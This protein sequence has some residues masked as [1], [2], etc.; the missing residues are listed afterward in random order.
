M[1]KYLAVLT[2]TAFLGTGC[3]TSYQ[4]GFDAGYTSTYSTGYNQTYDTGV[5]N[6]SADG[7]ID[8]S[9][10][11]YSDGH[12]QGYGQG[13]DDAFDIY[14]ST[15]YQNGYS[16]GSTSGYN[17]GYS[18]GTTLGSNA[19]YSDG[20]AD[21]QDDSYIDNYNM[22]YSD[23]DADGYNDGYAT[24]YGDYFASGYGVGYS[25]GS[26][27]GYNDGYDDG[28][29]DGYYD[30]SMGFSAS[31]NP[32][33]ALAAQVN[34]DLVDYA[35]LP[36][37]DKAQAVSSMALNHADGG[38]VDLEK[39]AAL[40][41][42]HYLGAIKNQLSAKFGLSASSAG[43]IANVVHQFNK[44]AGSRELTVEDASAFSKNLVGFDMASI[45]GAVKKS[46]KG[47]SNDLDLLLD[48]AAGK[49]DMSPENFNNMITTIFF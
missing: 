14:A 43:K 35:A 38:S 5:A 22:G 10:D 25:D 42:Q 40:K 39:L 17:Q 12:T 1:N 15:D 29:D 30:A 45:E 32:A 37:F 4:K 19:G 23:G 47:E 16:A 28:F 44:T 9:A 20:Y 34:S 2:V 21:G 48:K 7:A 11:G 26:T 33:I 27:V 6:G 13:Y 18:N 8:G 49:L 31:K 36:K 41:E 3:K 46:A 24:G